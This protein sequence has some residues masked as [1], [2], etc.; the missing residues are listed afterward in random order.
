MPYLLIPNG[1]DVEIHCTAVMEGGDPPIWTIDLSADS[2][3]AQHQFS[4]RKGLLNAYG[5]Y[6]LPRIETPVTVRLLINDTASNNLTEINC[7]HGTSSITTILR[8]FGEF[9]TT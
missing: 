8:V 6:E 2:S 7:D 9:S 1:S 5:V 4:T 3:D